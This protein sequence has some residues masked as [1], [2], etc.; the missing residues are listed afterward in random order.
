M[1]V[2]F[3]QQK[4]FVEFASDAINKLEFYENIQIIDVDYQL[5]GLVR[6]KSTYLPVLFISLISGITLMTFVTRSWH[7]LTLENFI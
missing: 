5:E 2:C 4:L 7:F 6:C 3:Q 1:Q